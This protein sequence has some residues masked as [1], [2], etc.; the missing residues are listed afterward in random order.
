MT[1]PAANAISL[2]EPIAR[3]LLPFVTNPAQYVSG[4]VNAV[5]KDWD[6]AAVRM[7]LA[8]PDTYGIGMSHLGSAIVYDLVN[9]RPDAL[10]ER[11]YTPWG[12][13]Q[14]RMRTLGLPLFAWESRRPVRAFDL[15]GFSL[16]Y[17]ML[18]TNVLAMLDLA[19]IPLTAAERG[20]DDPLVLAGGPGTNNPEPM[21]D[22]LDLVYVGDAEAALPALLD[23]YAE[24]KAAGMPRAEM[25]AALARAF[26]FLYAPGLWAPRW[27]DDGRLAAIEPTTDGLPPVTRAAVV[28]DLDRTPFPTAPV[29]PSAE[30]VHDR[31]TIEIMRGCPRRC[32]FCEA[33]RTKGP[34]R[35]RR[36]ETVVNIAREGYANTG[37]DEISLTSLSPSDHPN[38]K[39]IMTTLD[40]EFGPRGVS[41]S[42]PSLRTNDQLELVPRLLGSVRKSGLTM[43]PEA[44]LP[45]LRRVIGKNIQEEHLLAG[46][47]EAWAGGWNLI[48]LYFMVGLPTETDEDLA[49]VG[50]LA[51][52]VS[53]VRRDVAKGPGKVNVAVANFVPKPH[54]PFQFHPMADRDYL[55]AAR[56]RLY[57]VLKG[58]RLSLKVHNVDRSL[59]EGVLARGDRRIGRV[60]LE[61]Y[62]A[63]AR[64]DAWDE[65]FDPEVWRQAFEAAGVDPAFYAHRGRDEDEVLPWDHIDVG[66]DRAALWQEYQ[67][68]LAEA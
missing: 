33:G 9:R 30:T 31:L 7:C 3:D 17:E 48:K 14:D 49:A 1:R 8:F 41:L 27:H 19:G 51:R 22:F 44:G 25:I 21:A 28:E 12:D 4:E 53:N 47:R 65:T 50:H 68:A 42:L 26:D 35:H 58:K 64:F 13:A 15:L 45:R 11:T 61:A 37:Y 6:T 29:V 54:T 24:L 20:E 39:E 55:T 16:Q 10:C 46:A 36:P 66:S 34:V 40:A 59:L 67:K 62:R 60:V 63:G 32:R 43:V 5:Q 57:G 52:K 23:R 2:A 56:E 38:L 18:Y